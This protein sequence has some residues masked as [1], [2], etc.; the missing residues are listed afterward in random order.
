MSSSALR[1]AGWPGG[2]VAADFDDYQNRIRE[3][4]PFSLPSDLNNPWSMAMLIGTRDPDIE[5]HSTLDLAALSHIHGHPDKQNAHCLRAS[6][7][8]GEAGDTQAL[9]SCRQ[10]ILDELDQ[11]L[12]GET[13]DKQLEGTTEARVALVFRGEVDVELQRYGF[14]VGRALHALQDSFSHTFRSSDAT[15]VHSVLNWVDW[16]EDDYDSARDG[17]NHLSALDECSSSAASQLRVNHAIAASTELLL[18]LSD[19]DASNEVRIAK[20]ADVIDRHLHLQPG[21]SALNDWCDAPERF[22]E[23]T[24]G[25][26]VSQGAQSASCLA[27]LV[28]VF[29]WLYCR[30]ARVRVAFFSLFLC[31]AVT[32][33]AYAQTHRPAEDAAVTSSS[34]AP[35][36]ASRGISWG[37]YAATGASLDHGAFAFSLGGRAQLTPNL[38]LGADVEYNP[39][40]S[41]EAG[42]FAEG[43]INAYATIVLAWARIKNVELRSSAHVGLSVLLFDLVGADEGSL[44]PFGALTLLGIGWDFAEHFKWVIDPAQVAVPMPQVTGIPFY[45][46]QYRFVTGIQWMF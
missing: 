22:E 26:S 45:Y 33:D 15:T 11:A 27:F 20:A 24:L 14:H 13:G 46:I 30:R 29:L 6:I 9:A 17:H 19:L 42:E 32:N 31:L 36:R 40:F 35:S 5:G 8:D 23:S 3:D 18:S 2:I 16:I 41:L 43:V 4:L 12:G 10:F 21:C 1:Q 44:G 25:C 39:W 38:Y 37:L 7:D 28:C 34:G